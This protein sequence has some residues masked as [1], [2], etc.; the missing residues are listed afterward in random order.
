MTSFLVFLPDD[1]ILHVLKFI[2]IID[3]QQMLIGNI[4][5]LFSSLCA[6]AIQQNKDITL[7]IYDRD[8][9]LQHK[10]WIDGNNG[11]IS[12]IRN[13]KIPSIIMSADAPSLSIKHKGLLSDVRIVSY[14]LGT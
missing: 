6:R 8:C 10:L 9:K 2:H 3:L 5:R 13:C 7:A 1:V 4:S 12:S 14:S 11:N